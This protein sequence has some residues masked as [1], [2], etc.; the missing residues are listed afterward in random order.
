ME[1][2]WCSELVSV[3]LVVPHCDRILFLEPLG[4]EEVQERKPFLEHTLENT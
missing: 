1:V 4:E 3:L 2:I